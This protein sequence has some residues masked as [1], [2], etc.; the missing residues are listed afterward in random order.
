MN[1]TK[2]VEMKITCKKCRRTFKTYV[3]T[4]RLC[5]KCKNKDVITPSIQPE[6]KGCIYVE[7][8]NILAYQTQEGGNSEC[9]ILKLKKSG[10]N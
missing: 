10:E 7:D 2:K 8:C 5:P 4:E 6:C 9:I 3:F 1:K